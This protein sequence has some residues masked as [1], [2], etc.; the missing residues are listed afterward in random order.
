M[1]A[2]LNSTLAAG[3][4]EGLNPAE[5]SVMHVDLNSC[6]ATIEQQ[7]HPHLRGK[8]LGVTNRVTKH[9][10][11]IALS[12]EAKALGA[13]VGM[14][15]DE[16]KAFIPDLIVLET[17]PPKYH[18][19][20][21]KLVAIM[22]SYSPHVQ[23]KSIDEGVI[24][25]AGTRQAINNR[26]LEEIG[27]EIKERLRDELGCWMKCNVGIAPNRFLAKLAAGFD[28]P[29]GLT[30]LDHTNIRQRYATIKLTDFPGIANRFEAR[31]NKRGI[32]SPTDFLN[33]PL[34]TLHKN[35]FQS[36]IGVHWH[37]RIRGYE[38]DNVET[39]LGIVGKQFVLDIRTNDEHELKKRF[40]YLCYTAA[41]KLRYN[42]MRARG[43]HVYLAFHG[44][45][46]WF[47]RHLFP[48]PFFSDRA[49]F[50]NA[51]NILSRRPKDRMIQMMSI[52]C[53][54]LSP[55]DGAPT[56]LELFRDLEKEERI[57]ETIDEINDIYGLP[58]ITLSTAL[59]AHGIVKQ[60]VPFGSTKYFELL[61]KRA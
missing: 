28:K 12:Y 29:D 21:E 19:A 18:H 45:G 17:D 14:R 60:K 30:I 36:V 34:Y 9:C 43:V 38:V 61:C 37:Q 3:V 22:K 27:H 49:V 5:P 6:F 48:E 24:D 10:C 46:S 4:Q 7:A 25:F 26:P 44:G 57:T 15:Y 20:Y 13:K 52:T 16:V 11:M 35:V 51:M 2:L 32:M 39:N 56:Q 50:E 53:Y 42:E 8:P 40:A 1:T 58:A 33:A 55:L 59:S 41:R 31:L 23:M 54:H 47:K